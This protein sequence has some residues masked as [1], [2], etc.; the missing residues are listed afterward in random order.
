MAIALAASS[1][2]TSGNRARRLDSRCILC[3]ALAHDRGP[4]GQVTRRYA[5]GTWP[6][7]V[8]RKSGRRTSAHPVQAPEQFRKA[9]HDIRFDQGQGYLFAQTWDNIFVVRTAPTQSLRA[10]HQRPLTRAAER[11]PTSWLRRC[12]ILM[13]AL[14]PTCSPDQARHKHNRRSPTSPALGPG[15]SCR[16][17]QRREPVGYDRCVSVGRPRYQHIS[18]PTEGRHAVA[19]SG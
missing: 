14:S 11:W 13:T 4:H 17:D 8:T 10:P 19:C 3:H 15:I 18:G 6:C 7:A 12:E 5:N 2:R 9:A 16:P 1:R